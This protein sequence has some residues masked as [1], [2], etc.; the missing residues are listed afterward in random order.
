MRTLPF[1]TPYNGRRCAPVAKESGVPA[2]RTMV[3]SGPRGHTLSK[4]PRSP[5]R[6]SKTLCG[7]GPGLGPGT[8]TIRE[9]HGGSS[10]TLGGAPPGMCPGIPWPVGARGTGEPPSRA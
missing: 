4:C 5:G 1:Q 9:R 8:L 10:S 7:N 3:Y 6:A 2:I